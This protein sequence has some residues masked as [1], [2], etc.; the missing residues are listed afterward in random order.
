MHKLKNSNWKSADQLLKELLARLGAYPAFI[1]PDVQAFLDD[2]RSYRNTYTH[3]TGLKG[4][5]RLS[6][7]DIMVHVG[8]AQLLAYGALAVMLGFSPDKAVERVRSSYFKQEVRYRANK[9]Y[10]LEVG[11]REGV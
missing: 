1:V 6:P 11:E 9:L 5:R 10:A 8:A 7:D 3:W 4:K 2:H